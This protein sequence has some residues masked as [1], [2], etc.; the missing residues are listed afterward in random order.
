LKYNLKIV[1]S[2]VKVCYSI[3]Y[4]VIFALIRGVS[5]PEEIGAVMDAGVALLA[6]IFCSD[7]Y[8][9]EVQENR[10]EAFNLIPN[11]NRYKTICQRL[12][13]QMIYLSILISLGYWLFYLKM[14]TFGTDANLLLIYITAVLA[15]SASVLF[16]G[17]LSFTMVN[18][19]KNVWGGIGVTF[20]IW[21]SLNSTFGKDI[22]IYLNVFGYTFR[23]DMG[24][25]RDL[26][27]EKL[28][29]VTISILLIYSNRRL[30]V[31]KRKG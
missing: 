1:L 7:A 14:I 28:V 3:S 18:A 17:T 30:L 6:I 2:R 29:A 10:W 5:S 31:S 16:F 25:S 12:L 15:C 11:R 27:I 26:I 23:E 21:I 9:Q 13:L 22:P 4:V 19:F 8:Y 20:L 24:I